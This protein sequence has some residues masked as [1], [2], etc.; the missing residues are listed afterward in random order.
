MKAPAHRKPSRRTQAC[1]PLALAALAAVWLGGAALPAPAAN[2]APPAPAAVAAPPAPAAVAAPDS[3]PVE[4]QRK[5]LEVLQR[6][7]DYSGGLRAWNA[8][9]DVRFRLVMGTYKD[10]RVARPD[11]TEVSLRLRG[12]PGFREQ[13][14]AWAIGWDGGMA[15]FRGGGRV[16]V[17]PR[18]SAMTRVQAGFVSWWFA[19][20]FCFL[21]STSECAYLG[22][23]EVE[24]RPC[25]VV[26][27]IDHRSGRP[28]ERCDV[29]SA[30]FDPADGRFLGANFTRVDLGETRPR[31]ATWFDDWVAVGPLLLPSTQRLYR[32][33]GNMLPDLKAPQVEYRRLDMRLDAGAPDSLFAL[34]AH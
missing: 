29:T 24:G 11:T 9:R 6:A 22:R 23:I 4:R 28:R 34:P 30:Y 32:L 18:D 31:L 5:A 15:W 14:A 27:V 21:D 12:K 1:G 3:A 33:T 25:E 7:A 19:A 26:Q 17:A 13:A 16:S 2:A 10:G 20:P 8:A